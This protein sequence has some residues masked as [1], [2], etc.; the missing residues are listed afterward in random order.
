MEKCCTRV[1]NLPLCGKLETAAGGF[2]QDQ[3]GRQVGGSTPKTIA[4]VDE[5]FGRDQQVI[6]ANFSSV[7]MRKAR[8][9]AFA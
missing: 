1:M 6:G 8:S 9:N 3:L 2:Y 4:R 5:I 7:I